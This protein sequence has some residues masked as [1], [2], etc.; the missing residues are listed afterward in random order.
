MV[1][2]TGV[3]TCSDHHYAP[4][5]EC[6][7]FI[8]SPTMTQGGV[9]ADGFIDNIANYNAAASYKGGEHESALD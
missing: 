2:W 9:F 8:V 4:F 5:S 7:F 1:V 3:V 6:I